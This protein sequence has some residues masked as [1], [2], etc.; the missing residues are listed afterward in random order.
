MSIYFNH[1]GI[2]WIFLILVQGGIG[3]TYYLLKR[4]VED[5]PMELG[6]TFSNRMI[7]DEHPGIHQLIHYIMEL[8][9][10]GI[11]ILLFI[12]LNWVCSL[13]YILNVYIGRFVFY[14]LYTNHF[15]IGSHYISLLSFSNSKYVYLFYIRFILLSIISYNLL[16]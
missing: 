15:I 13:F 14:A 9:N 7:L 16:T 1:F 11:V 3:K 4:T 5:S 2:I 12:N 10:I 8:M 6:E